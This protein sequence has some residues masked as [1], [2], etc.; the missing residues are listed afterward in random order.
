MM[1]TFQNAAR[2]EKQ[3]FG[4]CAAVH[5]KGSSLSCEGPIGEFPAVLRNSMWWLGSGAYTRAEIVRAGEIRFVDG[6]TLVGPFPCVNV[7]SGYLYADEVLVA[8]YLPS[9]KWLAVADNK[10][11]EGVLISRVG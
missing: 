1:I 9:G 2:V 5:L 4:P 11:Y 7:I 3:S 10:E 8:R 6:P